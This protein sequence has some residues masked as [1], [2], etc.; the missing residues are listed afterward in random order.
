[1]GIRTGTRL[2]QLLALQ[3]RIAHEIDVERAKDRDTQAG[4]RVEPIRAP[5]K[6]PPEGPIQ[7][8]ATLQALGVDARTVREWARARGHEVPP[9]GPVSA[10]LVEAYAQAHRGCHTVPD[11]A[12]PNPETQEAS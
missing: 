5:K 3:R 1:M 4:R 10:D 6:R 11:P 8:G 12:T 2:E 9:R 7:L